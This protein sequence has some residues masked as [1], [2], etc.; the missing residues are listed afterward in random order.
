MYTKQNRCYISVT[1][2]HILQMKKLKS[3]YSNNHPGFLF[4]TSSFITLSFH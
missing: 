2:L 4:H 1:D 3:D